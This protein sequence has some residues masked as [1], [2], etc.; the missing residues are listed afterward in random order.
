MQ[1]YFSLQGKVAVV[2]GGASGI[3]LAVARRFLNSG[4]KV[5]IG[6]LAV[7]PEFAEHPE[8]LSLTVDVADFDAMRKLMVT[9][10]EAFGGLDVLV[11]NA[12]VAGGYRSLLDSTNEDFQRCYDINLMGVVNGIKAAVPSMPVG[13]AI[14]NTASFAGVSAVPDISSYVASKHAVVGVTR[15]AAIELADQGIR[16]NCVCPTTVNTPMAQEEEGES[17]VNFE[18]NWNP[19]QRI[20]EPEEVAALIHFLASDDSRFINGQ[21]INICG[22]ATAGLTGRAINALSAYHG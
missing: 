14:V 6:D 12:G 13:A 9:A 19:Q 3:G 22:G 15:S 10:S 4:G 7:A 17:L 21:A 16:V 5:V 18:R 20:C 2:T 8:C 1:D 11:N